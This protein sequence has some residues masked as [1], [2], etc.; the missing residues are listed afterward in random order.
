MEGR[1]LFNFIEYGFHVG[2]I[3]EI[4]SCDLNAIKD[5]LCVYVRRPSV[6]SLLTKNS[7]RAKSKDNGH[8]LVI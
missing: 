4:K 6:G 2:S 3:E 7:S 5:H 1:Q 8:D